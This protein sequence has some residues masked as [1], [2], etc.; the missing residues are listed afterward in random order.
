[1]RILLTGGS[2]F[3]GRHLATALRSEH[4]LIAPGREALDLSLSSS[5]WQLPS[6]VDAVIHAA[7]RIDPSETMRQVNVEGTRSLCE[8]AVGAGARKML[9][10]STGG[11]H[12]T[13]EYAATKRD[14]EGV[15]DAFRDRMSVITARLYFP[16]GPGQRGRFIPNLVRSISEGKVVTLRGEEGTRLSVIYIDDLVDATRR[17]LA[18]E[19]N[20]TLDV[21]P[22]ETSVREIAMLIGELVGHMPHF[23]VVAPDRDY[24]ADRAPLRELTGFTPTVGLR[25]GLRRTVAAS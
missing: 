11:V 7:A 18:L 2:G 19:S 22:Q 1:M 20:V 16:Y 23:E 8:W 6:H 21:A 17:L 15:V 10:F 12:G 25:E 4:E 24:L 5:D 3:V 14:A 13:G 9:F